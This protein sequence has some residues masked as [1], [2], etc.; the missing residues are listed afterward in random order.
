MQI[1]ARQAQAIIV[2]A[3][4]KALEMQVPVSISVLDASGH[5][6]LFLRMDH[7]VLGSIDIALKKA[8]TSVLFEC[9]SE[10]VWEFC[11]PGAP[12]PGLELTN[13]VLAAFAGGMPM[14]LQGFLIGAI[15]VSGGTPAQDAE[16]AA[17]GVAALGTN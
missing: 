12:A 10:A 2:A 6:K 16:I 15:G 3:Q 8:K 4:D 9:R 11:K 13:G 17:A 5:A 14:R 7:A 1:T